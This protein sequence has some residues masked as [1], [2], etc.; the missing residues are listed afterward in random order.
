MML[1]MWKNFE[2]LEEALSIEELE[3]LLTAAREKEYRNFRAMA[4]VQG[5]DLDDGKEERNPLE[6]ARMKLE[7]EKRGMKQ[8]H[9]E[10]DM[11]G[12]EIEYED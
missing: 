1:G 9:L 5:I 7:A 10:I 12:F 2:E 6:E 4:A 3:S 8:D 11:L